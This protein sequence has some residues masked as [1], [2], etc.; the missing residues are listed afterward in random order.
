MIPDHVARLRPRVLRVLRMVGVAV[1]LG[2]LSWACSLGLFHVS[3][4][5]HTVVD[6]T[7]YRSGQLTPEQ[8]S[9]YVETYDIKT[10]INLRDDN[11]VNPAYEPEV[12]AARYLGV[13]HLDFQMSAERQLS[14]A[15]AQ[16]LVALLRGAEP[17]IL[18]HCKAG[19]D[20][21]GLASA[22][23]LAAILGRDLK[24]ASGQL[25]IQ[26]GHI[27]LPF[28]PEYAMDRTFKKVSPRLV[29]ADTLP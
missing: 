7:L 28:V 13:T 12:R 16:D 4:N 29:L 20:R 2:V 10:I 27:A 21:T 8:I 5:F 3:G 6:R 1:G 18:I 19:A 14:S 9:R 17:P 25:S 15:Q 22:L 26:Y 24:T 23:Y 11:D